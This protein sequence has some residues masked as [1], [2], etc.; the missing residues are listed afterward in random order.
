MEMSI[1]R[2]SPATSD[3]LQDTDSSYKLQDTSQPI[4][5]ILYQATSD[6][7]QIFQTYRFSGLTFP[8]K[9]CGTDYNVM[10]LEC[11]RQ[12]FFLTPPPVRPK[13][14][15]THDPSNF[16]MPVIFGFI[17]LGHFFG[18]FFFNH[19]FFVTFLVH[20]LRSFAWYFQRD[21]V[22]KTNL[23]SNYMR[24]KKDDFN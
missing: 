18:H 5:K 16:W 8:T 12:A 1:E 4:C 17:F 20:F 6:K 21:S 10:C 14:Q 3:K 22:M 7:L 13:V 15:M 24:P 19:F 23:T 11:I 9:Y 2:P